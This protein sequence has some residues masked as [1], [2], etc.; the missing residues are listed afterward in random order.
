MSYYTLTHTKTHTHT[1]SH[2]VATALTQ[3]S[4]ITMWLLHCYYTAIT[5]LLHSCYTLVT[6]LL[7]CCYTVGTLLSHCCYTVVTLW[8]DCCY[9]GHG[10]APEVIDHDGVTRSP[11]LLL[12]CVMTVW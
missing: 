5:L 1:H 3:R 11:S 8:L 6:L 7:H 9:R 4:S 10:A 12:L 2:T